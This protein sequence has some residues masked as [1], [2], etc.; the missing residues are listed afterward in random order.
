MGVGAVATAFG[1]FVQLTHLSC[2]GFRMQQEHKTFVT[3]EDK[4]QGPGGRGWD[5]VLGGPPGGAAGTAVP[6]SLA[7]GAFSSSCYG[8]AP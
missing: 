2:V 6:K 7:S 1:I 8:S 3:T 5:Q 4:D